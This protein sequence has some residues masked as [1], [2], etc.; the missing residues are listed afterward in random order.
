MGGGYSQG[1]L[2]IYD[3]GFYNLG[4]L[5]VDVEIDGRV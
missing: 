3:P 2:E 5:C 4:V 1:V